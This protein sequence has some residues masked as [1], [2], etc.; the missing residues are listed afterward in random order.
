M[1]RA[2]PFAIGNVILSAEHA[3]PTQYPFAGT[4]EPTALLSDL[5]DWANQATLGAHD[6]RLLLKGEDFEGTELGLA[7][8]ASVT[9]RRRPS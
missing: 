7:Y 3:H 5:N 2:T 6:L 8:L 4:L 1:G 9:R